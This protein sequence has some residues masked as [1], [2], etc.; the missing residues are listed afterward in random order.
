MLLTRQKRVSTDQNNS[1]NPSR[2]VQ[3]RNLTTAALTVGR[4]SLEG[5]ASLFTSGFTPE[6]NHTA[7]LSVGRVSPVQEVLSYTIESIQERIRT[8]VHSVGRVSLLLTP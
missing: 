6:R 2:E 8:D 4:V 3:G 7:A 5:V 1:G